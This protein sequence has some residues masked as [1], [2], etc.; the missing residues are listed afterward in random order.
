MAVEASQPLKVSVPVSAALAQALYNEAF[1]AGPPAKYTLVCINALGAADLIA[2]NTD[3]PIG[4]IQNTP[5]VPSQTSSQLGGLPAE[6]VILGIT[7][8]VAGG[9]ITLAATTPGNALKMSVASSHVGTVLQSGGFA[10]SASGLS[11]VG[12]AFEAA[13][14]GQIL[15]AL[16]NC[17]SPLPIG[18]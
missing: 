5:Y 18:S 4:V 12:Q 10:T 8:V 17:A 2:N 1:A 6:I 11:I 9:T 7:K 13:V 15:K 14:S 3:V 16:I